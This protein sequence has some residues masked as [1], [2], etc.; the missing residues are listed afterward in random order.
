MYW[1]LSQAWN[2]ELESHNPY[3]AT[4][5]CVLKTY[6]D[7]RLSCMT[8]GKLTYLSLSSPLCKMGILTIIIFHCHR[9]KKINYV[10]HFTWC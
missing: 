7:Q 10:K 5:K 8:A 4:H 1:A 2:I 6:S 9:L 3:Q